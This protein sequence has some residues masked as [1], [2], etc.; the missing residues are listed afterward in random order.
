MKQV[1][2]MIYKTKSR[3][4][5][6]KNSFLAGE[7]SSQDDVSVRAV[8]AEKLAAESGGILGPADLPY[9]EQESTFECDGA[10]RTYMRNMAEA[11]P[12]TT[13]NENAVWDEI[14]ELHELM[15]RRLYPFPFVVRQHVKL[16]EKC[17]NPDTLHE[18]F[19]QSAIQAL[20][21]TGEVIRLM[22]TAKEELLDCLKELYSACAGGDADTIATARSLLVELMM[23]YPVQMEQ[24]FRCFE[25]LRS[26]AGQLKNPGAETESLLAGELACTMEE[27]CSVYQELEG[28]YHL[29]EEKRRVLAEG[30]LR[31]VVSI[32]KKFQG[33]GV[34]FADLIQEGNIG[35]MKALDKF[36]Y[37]LGHR[38]STYATWWI[39]QS[40]FHAIG[41][42]ARVIRL[43]V[44]MLTTL[45]KISHAEQCFLQEHGREATVE[46]IAAELEMTR[47]RVNSMKRMAMQAI[48][49]QA[50][51]SAW[52]D[53]KDASVEDTVMTLRDDDDPM[54]SFAQKLLRQK[55]FE[56][57]RTLPARSREVLTMRYGLDGGRPKSLTEVSTYFNISR[58]R[59]RQIETGA[60]AKLR[61]P[62]TIKMFEDYFS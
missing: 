21:G 45:N 48:S 14:A 9:M 15:R 47:E 26:Y 40:V 3:N 39:K 28:V 4:A 5:S 30:N 2:W 23:T 1:V 19:S 42:Q 53:G 58:E 38:F 20:G 54:R 13:E 52:N 17:R 50:P 31:L 16:F 62:S 61:D 7:Q 22:P 11:V 43:P 32:A 57:I 33:R 56:T 49:L 8:Q 29:L 10:L 44:H 6:G 46:E 24:I 18:V 51:I 12:L 37:K 27:F 34:P 25:T 60:I 35:L 36:D 59:I 41:R 55:L